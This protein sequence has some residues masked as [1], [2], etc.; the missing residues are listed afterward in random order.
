MLTAFAL[1]DLENGRDCKLLSE[2]ENGLIVGPED[3]VTLSAPSLPPDW[4]GIAAGASTEL[5]MLLAGVC[6]GARAAGLT[7][8]ANLLPM[9]VRICAGCMVSGTA[10]RGAAR[11]RIG[12]CVLA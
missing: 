1:L 10:L 12:T 6:R 9:L 5:G 11:A 8:F 3:V 2:C 7:S 4:R